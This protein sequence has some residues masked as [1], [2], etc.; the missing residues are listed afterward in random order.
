MPQLCH[1]FSTK[2]IVKTSRDQPIWHLSD[3]AQN[4]TKTILDD[5]TEIIDEKHG[6][7]TPPVSQG[8]LWRRHI[9]S[10]FNV[11]PLFT[12]GICPVFLPQ[13]SAQFVWKTSRE[14]FLFSRKHFPIVHLLNWSIC[15]TAQSHNQGI[16]NPFIWWIDWLSPWHNHTIEESDRSVQSLNRLTHP[17]A[18]S[19]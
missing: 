12:M 18:Q 3:F 8:W 19:V 15:P 2:F 11:F 16:P 14:H 13:T 10:S 6:I 9:A 7:Q 5:Y 17:T 1:K 4:M